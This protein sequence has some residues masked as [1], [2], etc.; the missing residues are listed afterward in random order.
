MFQYQYKLAS[1]AF[2]DNFCW[3]W[4]VFCFS[5][6]YVF[7]GSIDLKSLQ[8]ENACDV[9]PPSS[10]SLNYIALRYSDFP[11]EITVSFFLDFAILFV[12]YGTVTIPDK[13][14]FIETYYLLF[15][16]KTQK[17]MYT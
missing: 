4:F 16:Y 5:Y 1:M 9:I 2:P 6:F 11:P 13:D 10:R 12:S 7:G 17:P 3:I 8:V 15:Y 14:W